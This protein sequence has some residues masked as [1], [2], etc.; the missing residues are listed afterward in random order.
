MYSKGTGAMNVNRVKVL[1]MLKEGIIS[2]DDAERLLERLEDN[3]SG[4]AVDEADLDTLE[5]FDDELGLYASAQ[6]GPGASASARKGGPSEGANVQLEIE[7][8]GDDDDHGDDRLH[9]RIQIKKEIGTKVQDV[10]NAAMAAVARQLDK[11]TKDHGKHDHRH[12]RNGNG[13]RFVR[14]QIETNDG[15]EVDLRLPIALIRAG[16]KLTAL[17][18]NKAREALKDAG[19]D[20]D[21]LSQLDPEAIVKAI[22]ELKVDIETAD[23]SEISI[24]AE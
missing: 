11:R 9:K 14:I 10:A 20:I 12:D 18:P 1:Q 19:V 5:E 22:A 8:G 23:G 2:L 16:M 24:H 21:S 13:P 4:S 6:A 15:H 3:A 7:V 17:I